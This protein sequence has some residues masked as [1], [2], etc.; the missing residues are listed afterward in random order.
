MAYD[1]FASYLSNRSQSVLYNNSE[2]DHKEIK[3]GVP[4]VYILGPL[5]FWIYINDL[6]SV[7]KFFLPIL[8][9]DD[10]N[11]FCTGKKL[12]D[13]LKEINVEI[14]KIY[15]W[16]KAN[17]L[18][19]NVDKTNFMLF[20][21]KCFPCNMNDLINGSRISEVN[22]TKFLGV[23]IDNKLSWSSHIMYISNN[24]SKPADVHEYNTRNASTLHVFVC[25]Q[26]TTRGQKTLSYCGARIWN[27]V[28][29]NVD[30]NCAIGLLKNVS[31]DCSCSQTM[32]YL[33]DSATFWCIYASVVIML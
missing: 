28:L 26:R 32:T 15:S 1:W 23:I 27:Y 8:F 11:L 10:T 5:F 18:S 7:S 31:K 25:F 6:P 3:C 13:I 12:N 30:S 17:K 22:E 19:L 20:T 2:S 21:P 33:H 29:D 24:I 9:A 16:V 4:Q 14:D